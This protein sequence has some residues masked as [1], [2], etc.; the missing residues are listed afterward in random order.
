VELLF[1]HDAAEAE[2]GDQQVR[3]VFGCAE[4]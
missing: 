3:I 4:E 2:V 1:V